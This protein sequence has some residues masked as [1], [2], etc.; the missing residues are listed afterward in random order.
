MRCGVGHRHSS[1]LVL[2]WL[3]RRPV[4]AALFKP[5]ACEPPYAVGV[6]F[7]KEKRQKEKK[8]VRGNKQ[9]NVTECVYVCVL[10]VLNTTTI[11][12][13]VSVIK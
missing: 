4:A 8:K 13:F 11:I 5:L 12:L 2:L 6:A 7:E 1:D 3:W 9:R 10:V